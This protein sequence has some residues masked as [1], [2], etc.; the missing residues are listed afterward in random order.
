MKILQF[1]IEISK[2]PLLTWNSTPI[3]KLVQEAF[4]DINLTTEDN[5]QVVKNS[6]NN[7]AY[8]NFKSIPREDDLKFSGAAKGNQFYLIKS[9]DE[10]RSNTSIT[11]R[12]FVVSENSEF[13]NIISVVVNEIN[14]VISNIHPWL[15]L[16][17]KPIYEN[18]I[19]IYVFD[20]EEND[21]IQGVEI[22][23]KYQRKARR[24]VYKN[25]NIA[26]LIISIISLSIGN[27]FTLSFGASGFFWLLLELLISFTNRNQIVIEDIDNLIQLDKQI[28]KS[29]NKEG[30][31]LQSPNV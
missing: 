26:V 18:F 10:A 30:S 1:D 6:W 11:Y 2:T 9:D 27:A 3:E 28:F 12:V 21:I 19:T 23:G 5:E 7:L 31:E 15:F 29:D 25:R 24:S 14:N 17:Y 16:R 8:T 4:Y 20:R 13:R 22:K